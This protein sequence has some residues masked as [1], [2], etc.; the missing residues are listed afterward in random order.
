MAGAGTP[1][2]GGEGAAHIRRGSEERS[3]VNGG[4]I[5]PGVCLKP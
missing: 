4:G 5:A 2:E 1:G 3:C